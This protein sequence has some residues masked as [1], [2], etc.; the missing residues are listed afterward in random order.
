[1][2]EDN[3]KLIRSDDVLEAELEDVVVLVHVGSS[4]Y[5]ELN[6][7]GKQIWA[8][9]ASETNPATILR[10]MAPGRARLNDEEEQ[11]VVRYLE[12]L[13]ELE[14]VRMIPA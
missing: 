12:T 6:E 5:F 14:L 2:I 1:M 11:Q 3:P 9:L 4:R 13:I 8:L 10:A 7:T